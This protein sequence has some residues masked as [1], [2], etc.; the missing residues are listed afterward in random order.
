MSGE[1]IERDEYYSIVI[2]Y[3]LKSQIHAIG[4]I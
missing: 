2:E 4:N 1:Q 3:S